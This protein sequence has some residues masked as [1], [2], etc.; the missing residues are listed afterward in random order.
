M[1]YCPKC[2]RMHH[3]EGHQ[4]AKCWLTS[5]SDHLI[6]SIR[7]HLGEN[8]DGKS[9]SQL[10]EKFRMNRLMLSGYLK[11]YEEVG[12]LTKLEISTAIIYK[13]KR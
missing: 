9:I 1:W 2:N 6:E 13:L 4:G 11:A 10:S 5:M 7:K 3:V 8:P 12:V